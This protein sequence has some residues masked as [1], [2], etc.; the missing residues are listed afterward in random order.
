MRTP[1]LFVFVAAG[2]LGAAVFASFDVANSDPDD[3]DRKRAPSAPDAICTAPG[4]LYANVQAALNDATC[5]TINLAYPG[6]IAESVTITR[7][8]T[9]DGGSLIGGITW[10]PGA[11]RTINIPNAGTQVT[12]THMNL[13][14]GYSSDNGGSVFNAG[15]LRLNDVDVINSRS[16]K[17]GGGIFSTGILTV[18]NSRLSSNRAEGGGGG[19]ISA[20]VVSVISS[21]FE[22]NNSY[23]GAGGA[24]FISSQ[25]LITASSVIS[26]SG[27]FIYSNPAISNSFGG[28]VHMMAGNLN[29][30]DSSFIDNWVNSATTGSARGGAIFA[31]ASTAI[32]IENSIF[33]GN[34]LMGGADGAQGGAVHAGNSATAFLQNNTFSGN[35]AFSISGVAQ[36]GA[37]WAGRN[38]DITIG[39]SALQ[40]QKLEGV[41]DVQGGGVYV[42]KNAT[43]NIAFTQILSGVLEQHLNVAQ[44]GG[45]FAGNGSAI[46]LT[47]NVING[48]MLTTTTDY[49]ARHGGGL[50]LDTNAVGVING[51]EISYNAVA[52]GVDAAADGGGVYISPTA[53]LTADSISMVGNEAW[54]YGTGVYYP[55]PGKG[56]GVY[57]GGWLT[58]TNSVLRENMA[59]YYGGGAYVP[60]GGNFYAEGTTFNSNTTDI[61]GGGLSNSGDAT[62]KTSTVRQNGKTL[63]ST[64][65]GQLYPQVY[66]QPNGG[67]IFNDG[68]VLVV[69]STLKNNTAST[70]GGGL[71]N[72]GGDATVRLS[73]IQGNDVVFVNNGFGGGIANTTSGTLTI[74]QSAIYSNTSTAFGGG[75]YLN[76]ADITMSNSTLSGNQSEDN[77]GALYFMNGSTGFLNGNTIAY[78]IADS[79]ADDVGDGGGFYQSSIVALVEF[80]NTILGVNDD[81]SPVTK[82]KDCSGIFTSSGN[83]L[84]KTT[85]G[86]T[87]VFLGSDITGVDPDLKILGDYGGPSWA[88]DLKNTSPALDQIGAGGCLGV[89]QRDAPRPVNVNCD[90]GSIEKNGVVPP[91]PTPTPTN[92][93]TRTPT[94]TPTFTST[95]T[96]TRT[97]TP[98]FTSTLTPTS[99]PTRTPTPTPTFTSTPTATPSCTDAYEP[100]DSAAQAKP[101]TAGITQTHFFCLNLDEDWAV[102]TSTAG[103]KYLIAAYNPAVGVNTDMQLI[104]PD[105]VTVMQTYTTGAI[106]LITRTLGTGAYYVRVVDAGADGAGKSYSLGVVVAQ[107]A[108]NVFVPSAMRDAPADW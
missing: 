89:D 33:N 42:G 60:T 51:G 2:L 8:V 90:I 103:T 88:H 25:G 61:Q 67:G 7:N 41:Q 29:V 101:I 30:Y 69:E 20:T 1:S 19:A 94:P 38:S 79:D 104:A 34:N 66:E 6:P 100:N 106:S 78:N 53:R 64:V 12:L 52:L 37:V 27:A 36:G 50:F 23:E 46:T 44:G 5:T 28:G 70:S 73:T 83:N 102:F 95:S 99:T 55:A 75:I 10:T 16:L 17:N 18:E 82:E 45:V 35:E 3:L 96:P 107:A 105:G 4:G 86:C 54:A 80:K 9:I 56:G 71:F 68:V 24:M 92:T 76:L 77:G 87:T 58:L 14:N 62:L 84:V 97:P 98:T 72:K 11:T 57:A 81:L 40:R 22:Y 32:T 49:L 31:G 15:A 48:N 91:T 59:R 26:Y 13:N 47:E 74:R 63:T 43:A 108:K 93:P 39:N 21:T 85:T 65:P